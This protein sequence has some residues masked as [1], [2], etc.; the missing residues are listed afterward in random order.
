MA[1]RD[2]EQHAVS[3]IEKKSGKMPRRVKKH[4]KYP[5]HVYY[6]YN[7]PMSNICKHQY[8]Q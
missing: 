4:D 1:G 6:V 5:E 8:V 7:G 3:I 2:K